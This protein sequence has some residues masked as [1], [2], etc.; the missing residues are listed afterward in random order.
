M[1]K[2]NLLKDQT[3]RTRKVMAP[4]SASPSIWWMLAVMLVVVAGLVATWYYLNRQV[5]ELTGKRNELQVES[6]RLQELRNQID[7]FEKMKAERQSRI[8]LIEQ[9]KANQTGPVLLMN[10][11]IRCIPTSASFWLTALDQKGDQVRIT[12]FTVRGEA[13]PDFMSNLVATGFFKS[14]DLELY[15]DQQKDAAKFILLCVSERRMFP[16]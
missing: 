4:S 12:G 10:H 14:I 11:I 13:V 8:D 6:T 2:V 7:E 16:E 1:I 9:L 5:V 15:E 3:V